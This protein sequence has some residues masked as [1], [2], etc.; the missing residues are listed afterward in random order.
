M[1][2][3]SFCHEI[4]V[5]MDRFPLGEGNRRICSKVAINTI[6]ARLIRYQNLEVYFANDIHL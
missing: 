4:R 3:P 5:A 2:F 1:A 6:L